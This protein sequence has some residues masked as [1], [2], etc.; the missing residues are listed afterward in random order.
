MTITDPFPASQH[1][2]LQQITTYEEYMARQD[3]L[4]AGWDDDDRR[5]HQLEDGDDA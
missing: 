4:Q 3:A 1:A 5:K 2:A